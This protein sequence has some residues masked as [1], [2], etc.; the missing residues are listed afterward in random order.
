MT[1]SDQHPWI[2]ICSTIY[3][4][5]FSHAFFSS[6][7][8][9]LK[10]GTLSPVQRLKFW[11]PQI[12]FLKSQIYIY[13]LIFLKIGGGGGGGHSPPLSERGSIPDPMSK[14]HCGCDLMAISKS[15]RIASHDT[16]KELNSLNFE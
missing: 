2:L 13:Y 7:A 5:A 15:Y 4:E 1:L 14:N 16:W 6:D 10:N 9:L 8:L 11:P 12:Y 3:Y